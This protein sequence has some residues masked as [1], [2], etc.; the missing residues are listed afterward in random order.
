MSSGRRKTFI[1]ELFKK[2]KINKLQQLKATAFPGFC[3][4]IQSANK[5]IYDLKSREIKI[6]TIQ[7]FYIKK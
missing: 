1:R 4:F 2:I 6:L 7:L 3:V 5:Y